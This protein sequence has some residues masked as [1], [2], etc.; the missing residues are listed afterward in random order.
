LSRSP[1][2]STRRGRTRPTIGVAVAD[3]V[4]SAV[5]RTRSGWPTSSVPVAT[6]APIPATPAVAFTPMRHGRAAVHRLLA[7]SVGPGLSRNEFA[8]FRR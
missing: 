1:P 8:T 6:D 7:V 5:G 2:S 4:G 3:L